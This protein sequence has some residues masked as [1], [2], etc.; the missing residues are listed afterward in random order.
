MLGMCILGG[1][2]VLPT[3]AMAAVAQSPTIKVRGQ[4]VDEMGEPLLGATVR[5]KTD[6]VEQP[7]I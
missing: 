2:T 5:I 1:T 6:K 7:P 4:V 3:P